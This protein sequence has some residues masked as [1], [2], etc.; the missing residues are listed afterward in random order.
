MYSDIYLTCMASVLH[1]TTILA[2]LLLSVW[3]GREAKWKEP[4]LVLLSSVIGPALPPGTSCPWAIYSICLKL[5][6]LFYKISRN[7]I[8]FP[9]RSLLV[10][11]QLWLRF[12][13]SVRNNAFQLTFERE[14][15]EVQVS[16]KL[17]EVFVLFPKKL[18]K[19]R[20]RLWHIATVKA[21][22]S[23][24]KFSIFPTKT[25][26][27]PNRIWKIAKSQFPQKTMNQN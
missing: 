9:L 21:N 17:K 26:L 15:N 4:C 22:I 19:V 14:V 3:R 10:H 7:W 25:N 2:E 11:S 13:S 1:E 27:D 18:R 5:D 24:W 12:F 20:R 23:K 6:C 8:K 16:L